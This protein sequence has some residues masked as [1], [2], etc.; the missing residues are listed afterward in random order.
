MELNS[1][2]RGNAKGFKIRTEFSPNKELR[3]PNEHPMWF[4]YHKRVEGS[5]DTIVC[6]SECEKA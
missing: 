5:T 3:C 1:V 4:L 2:R 6:C